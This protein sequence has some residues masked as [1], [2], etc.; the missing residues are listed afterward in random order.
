MI[1]TLRHTVIKKTPCFSSETISSQLHDRVNK[2]QLDP[3][4]RPRKEFGRESW[5]P[6]YAGFNENFVDKILDAV[7]LPLGSII[8]DPWNGSG[9]TTT[10]AALKGYKSVG[11]DI[12]PVT[13]LV[14][15]AKLVRFVDAENVHML[16]QRIA[17][18]AKMACFSSTEDDPLR[19]WISGDAVDLYR[20]IERLILSDLSFNGDNGEDIYIS[21]V[22][23]ALTP[24]KSFLFLALMRAS[25][26]L[27]SIRET[28]NPAWVRPNQ[29]I[30][31]TL[32]K[33]ELTSKWIEIVIKMASDLKTTH[34][35]HD[36]GSKILQG[37]ARAIPLP[38]GN[39]DL[40]LTS[41]PYCTRLDYVVNT[42]FE[43]AALGIGSQNEQYNILR[44]NC[45]GTPLSRR[46]VIIDLNDCPISIQKVLEKVRHHSSKASQSY[47]F[48]TY[49]QYFED[50][51]AASR[52]IFRILRPGGIAILVLQDS[53]YKDI[54]IDLPELWIDIARHIGFLASEL[55]SLNIG[56]S[57]AQSNRRSTIYRSNTL[58]R[59]AVV[60]LVKNGDH[61]ETFGGTQK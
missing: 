32:K 27:A 37:D 35:E 13:T 46:D 54:H 55:Q 5:Y 43:L 4:R 34:V 40:V 2:M 26:S 57:I 14:S 47:Y 48:K 38:D 50:A 17:E 24:L 44:R 39:I 51:V 33:E 10:V 16:S 60:L 9:T 12:N 18:E 53:Y 30:P 49:A 45:M 29:L 28:S 58:Y 11:I 42:S 20:S 8:L 3:K 56:K 25:R 59:E 41:P 6:Y 15:S 19:E 1:E 31:F 36:M 61:L 7:G 52:E 21:S 23:E 22:V